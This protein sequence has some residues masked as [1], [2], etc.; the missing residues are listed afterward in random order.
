MKVNNKQRII[1]DDDI[2]VT[3]PRNLGDSLKDVIDEQRKDIE[4]LKGNMKFIYAYGGIGGTGSGGSGDGSTTREPKLYVE[5]QNIETGDSRPVNLDINN[6][7][8]LILPKPGIYRLYVKLSRSGGERFIFKYA[9]GSNSINFASRNELTEANN[10]TYIN[11]NVSLDSNGSIK[12][13]LEDPNE[14]EVLCNIE[15][16]YIVTPHKFD[17]AFMYESGGNPNKYDS[18]NEHFLGDT[19]KDPF[20]N[21]SYD[22]ILPQASDIFVTY[23]IGDFVSEEIKCSKSSDTIR[24]YQIGRAHV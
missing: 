16:R 11:E 13:Y 3:S 17:I 12:I 6:T 10:H 8:P 23:N 5:L 20:I 14:E 24:I 19:T 4:T 22:I 7:N 15:Q 1:I 9:I 18:G 2:I 21:I